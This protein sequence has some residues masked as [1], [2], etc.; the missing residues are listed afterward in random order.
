M[1][2]LFTGSNTVMPI[3]NR[4]WRKRS[5]SLQPLEKVIR[6]AFIPNLLDDK[7]PVSDD[8][9]ALYALPGRFNGLGLDN[10]VEDAAHIFSDSVQVTQQLSNLLVAG[11]A[12]L[13]IDDEQL[14]KTKK[15]IKE[16]RTM[17][18]KT[19]AASLRAKFPRDMQKAMDVAQ[20]KGGSCL[21]TTLPLDK[22]D[23]AFKSKRDFR[24]L[25]RMRYRKEIPKLP[26]TCVCG[27]P[28]S[29]D[30][31]QICKRGGFIHM[32][33]DKEK[34]LFAEN[35]K[36]VY[37]DVEIEPQLDAIDGEVLDL[38]TANRSDEARS[39]V[40]VR[41]FWG[42]KQNTFFECRVFYPFA[43]SHLSDSISTNYK[44]IAK[45]RRNEY[46]QRITTID[47]ASFTPLIMSSSGTMGPEMTIAVKY[48]AGRIAAKTHEPY[49]KVVSVLRCQFAFAAMRSA[50][51]CLRGS[52]DMRAV[53]R[54][55]QEMDDASATLI[56]N[57]LRL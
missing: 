8:M 3:A 39:D 42:N 41:G 35:C 33:H 4:P 43:K 44:T 54:N 50:L 46:E 40:R 34:L 47:N 5:Y 19:T 22:Y 2:H 21:I 14:Q 27:K 52:R 45:K 51:V 31:S 24:D 55:V 6:E 30:H 12:K 32:R 48:L 28:Y 11:E 16:R 57:D 7:T 36:K 20:E 53:S 23:L 13:V 37:K 10:P 18:H 29:L 25:L 17:R 38:K 15:E 26:G 1:Q 56:A 49:Q 9:R